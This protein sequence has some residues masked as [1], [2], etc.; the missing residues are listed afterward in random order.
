MRVRH[1][2]IVV[3]AASATVLFAAPAATAHP[4]GH[5]SGHPSRG[6]HPQTLTTEVIAPFHLDTAH[7]KLYVADGGTST[8]S[9]VRRDGSLRAVAMG[10]Q[11]GEVAGVA[12][13]GGSIAYT[14]TN[15]E[16][17]AAT[18]TVKTGSKSVVADLSGFEA[19]RNPD[20]RVHYGL[21]DP[22]CAVDVLGPFASYRGEVD[23]HPYAVTAW[24]DGS[25]IVA[26]AGGNDLLKVDPHGKVS[27]VA[28]LP[29]QPLLITEEFAQA[30]GVPDC[31]GQT[32]AFEPV[33]TD[34]EVGPDGMLYVTTLPGGPEDP[35]AGARGSVYKVNPWS[36]HA[37]RVATG[38]AGA[39]GLT[40]GPDRT[41]Y[42]AELFAGRV[43]KVRG[44]MPKA[45]ASLPGALAVEYGNGHLYAGTLAPFDDQ[46]NPTGTGSVVRLR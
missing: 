22:S 36:G 3:A 7:G 34:V 28:V 9:V 46:G 37:T 31:V 21:A 2:T 18:L 30:N 12:V 35:S 44:G 39:T 5:P 45:V 38:F 25:W 1:L 10:P 43:S 26:D 32:Y 33:P 27:L 8:V 24:R 4:S 42:V 41:I 16:T 19:K 15:Y 23:S 13:R 6:W 11:P 40:F 14:T 29:T 17:G 20:R